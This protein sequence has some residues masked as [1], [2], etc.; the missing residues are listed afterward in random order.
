[1]QKAGVSVVWILVALIVLTLVAI[2]ILLR[3]P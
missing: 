2:V 3:I 1:M